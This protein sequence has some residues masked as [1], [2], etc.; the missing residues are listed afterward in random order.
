MDLNK[1]TKEIEKFQQ[2]LSDLYY[3][4]SESPAFPTALIPET[5][6]ELGLASEELSVAVEE[7][8]M[9]RNCAESITQNHLRLFEC[10]PDPCLITNEFGI[11]L[12]VNSK[13]TSFL[14]IS[15]HFLI[16]EPLSD[17]LPP[18]E[19]KIFHDLLIKLETTGEPQSC[20]SL[21]RPRYS[22]PKQ[23]EFKVVPIC[24]SQGVFDKLYWFIQ[25]ISLPSLPTTERSQQHQ[26]LSV[27][28]TSSTYLK[29]EVIPLE[30]NFVWFVSSGVVK[31][32]TMG[33]K[34][35]TSILGFIFPSMTFSADFT[36]LPTF[37]ATSLTQEVKILRL[38]MAEITASQEQSKAFSASV[39]KR[40]QQAEKL[41]AIASKRQAK[42][43]VQALLRV[44]KEEIG[45]PIET[46]VRLPIRLTHTE[47]AEA[48]G[49][50]RVTVTRELRKLQKDGKIFLDADFCIVLREDE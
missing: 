16:R 48:C 34:G 41:L 13:A 4:A 45:E 32:T 7:L 28:S 27:N 23:V 40:L 49:T 12:E 35:E 31:L 15:K 11:I 22:C 20:N 18:S 46:W 26:T 38:S 42:Q 39:T 29:G 47:I 10:L 24:N 3:T 2:R 5:C 21:I 44:F 37:S 50:T 30:A 8:L 33:D 36:S 25:E 19:L 43:R 14:E 9:A 6:K 17:V 1:L